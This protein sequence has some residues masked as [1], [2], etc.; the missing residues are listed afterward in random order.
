MSFIKHKVNPTDNLCYFLV[1]TRQ[2]SH[3]KSMHSLFYFKNVLQ[4][5]LCV[6]VEFS[7][8]DRPEKQFVL[9]SAVHL[10]SFS[11]PIMLFDCLCTTVAMVL[12]L[13][14][15]LRQ[16]VLSLMW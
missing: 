8:Q 6:V 13:N 1:S 3:F 16:T 9:A 7:V 2:I 4:I 5:I 10:L 14:R 11:P 12:E 15:R